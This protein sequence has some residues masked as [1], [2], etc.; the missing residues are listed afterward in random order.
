M[1]KN[2]GI[3]FYKLIRIVGKSVYTVSIKRNC[4]LKKKIYIYICIYKLQITVIFIFNIE[5]KKKKKNYKNFQNIKKI[6]RVLSLNA[7]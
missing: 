1:K 2:F 4:I 5:T 3:K 7:I 6:F